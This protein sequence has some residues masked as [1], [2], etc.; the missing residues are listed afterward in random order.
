MNLLTITLFIVTLLLT[1]QSNIAQ[2]P[3]DPTCNPLVYAAIGP[4]GDGS[5][6]NSTTCTNAISEQYAQ[7][8]ECQVQLADD[9]LDD[10]LQVYNGY[11]YD[12][13]QAGFDLKNLT[14][15]LVSG[16]L[17]SETGGSL[18]LRASRSLFVWILGGLMS[19]HEGES[20]GDVFGARGHERGGYKGLQK[21]RMTR[22]TYSSSILQL[23]SGKSKLRIVDDSDVIQKLF[24]L[25]SVTCNTQTVKRVSSLR[26]RLRHPYWPVSMPRLSS[27]QARTRD[28]L[29]TFMTHHRERLKRLL[30]RKNRAQHAL[31]QAG[32]T[33]EEEEQLVDPLF[34]ESWEPQEYGI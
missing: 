15:S 5:G 8:L 34:W 9:N 22:T 32:V 12:C 26:A 23:I 13:F 30:R 33:L 21:V 31:A 25:S 17:P 7:C 24:M 29:K 4:E 16:G 3:C 11:L 1:V 19:R 18:H 14:T 10:A 6:A 28:V 20:Q 27:H 2:T